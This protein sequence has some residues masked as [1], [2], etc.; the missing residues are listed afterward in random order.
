MTLDNM[1]W[2]T[3][4]RLCASVGSCPGSGLLLRL[5]SYPERHQ[6]CILMGHLA[7]VALLF[8]WLS[9]YMVNFGPACSCS[10]M[11]LSP[12]AKLYDASRGTNN[13]RLLIICSQWYCCSRSTMALVYNRSCGYLKGVLVML[14]VLISAS[15]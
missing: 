14:D 12:V 2:S 10:E 13:K 6:G 4:V 8:L 15:P 3:Y 11:P 9:F 5:V 1:C 7:V